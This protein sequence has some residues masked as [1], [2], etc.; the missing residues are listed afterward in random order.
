MLGLEPVET[1]ATIRS[2]LAAGRR[3][4]RLPARA[5]ARDNNGF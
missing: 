4:P 5:H 1:A 2:A 3:F